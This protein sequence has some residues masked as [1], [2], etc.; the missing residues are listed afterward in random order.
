[1]WTSTFL[2]VFGNCACGGWTVVTFLRSQIICRFLATQGQYP[3]P[4][5]FKS[6]LYS[7]FTQHIV[8]LLE[9]QETEL[10]IDYFEGGES[11]V[12]LHGL[13]LELDFKLESHQ[14][15]LYL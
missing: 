12:K 6:Q 10:L 15:P 4:R 5:L 3:Q 9:L 14:N 7:H 1:M 11:V 8:R 2:S 13:K